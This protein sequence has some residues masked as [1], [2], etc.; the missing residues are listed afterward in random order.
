MHL[1]CRDNRIQYLMNNHHHSSNCKNYTRNRSSNTIN[2]MCNRCNKANNT[3]KYSNDYR[4]NRVFSLIIISI[5]N[6]CHWNIKFNNNVCTLAYPVPNKQAQTWR[7]LILVAPTTIAN[8]P[9][10]PNRISNHQEMVVGN[11]MR[12]DTRR[13]RKV[14][15]QKERWKPVWKLGI[16]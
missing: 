14:A 15:K 16:V 2:I 8:R 3:C 5:N 13:K 4:S 10:S 7:V 1:T 12:N 11:R 6:G 9:V